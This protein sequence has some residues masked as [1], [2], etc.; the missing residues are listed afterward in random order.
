MDKGGAGKKKKDYLAENI[1]LNRA[2]R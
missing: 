1:R 2:A